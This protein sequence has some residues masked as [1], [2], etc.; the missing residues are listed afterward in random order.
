MLS[1]INKFKKGIH[2]RS[3]WHPEQYFGDRRS[4]THEQCA[5]YTFKQVA[6]VNKYEISREPGP[7]NKYPEE[8]TCVFHHEG[9]NILI[10]EAVDNYNKKNVMTVIFEHGKKAATKGGNDRM[11]NLICVLVGR[12]ASSFEHYTIDS[13]RDS[14]NNKLLQLCKKE[15]PTP[16]EIG[17]IKALIYSNP[18]VAWNYLAAFKAAADV[19]MKTDKYE[20][21]EVL[22]ERFEILKGVIATKKEYTGEYFDKIRKEEEA[23]DDM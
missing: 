3:A 12:Y 17:E 13:T 6:G 7:T 10:C 4:F 5:G 20:C 14:L 21:V 19:A 2:K 9:E 11:F 15:R 16:E 18:H 8:Y 23:S 22:V 1:H